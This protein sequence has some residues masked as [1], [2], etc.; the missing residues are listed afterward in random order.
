MAESRGLK[1]FSESFSEANVRAMFNQIKTALAREFGRTEQDIE[2]EINSFNFSEDLKN[3]IIKEFEKAEKSLGGKS[4]TFSKDLFKNLFDANGAEEQINEIVK[5]F[6]N[7]IESLIR[8]KDRINNDEIFFKIDTTQLDELIEKEE[9]LIE[10]EKK[11]QDLLNNKKSVSGNTRSINK[12]QKEIDDIISNLNIDTSKVI[13]SKE[14]QQEVNKSKK[15][16]KELE[17]ELKKIGNQNILNN[18]TNKNQINKMKEYVK[19]YQEYL[20]SVKS[21]GGKVDETIQ[22]DFDYF[23]KNDEIKAYNDSLL[24]TKQNIL[25]KIKDLI[26]TIYILK[27]S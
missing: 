21:S 12:V 5:I 6:E 15:S 16:V 22:S 23:M 18:T 17:N 7:K 1:V 25:L 9:R 4:F 10:L 2:N 26:V 27:W 11:R 8:V 3:K 20:E 13:D 24:E 19:L 14:I